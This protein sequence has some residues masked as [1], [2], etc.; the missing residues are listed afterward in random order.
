[1]NFVDFDGTKSF[2]RGCP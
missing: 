1:M 2:I